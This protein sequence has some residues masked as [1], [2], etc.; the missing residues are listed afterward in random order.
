MSPELERIAIQRLNDKDPRSPPMPSRCCE[1]TARKL[2]SRLCGGNL[3]SGM[4]S[5]KIALVFSRSLIAASK[6]IPRSVSKGNRL[7]RSR[8]Q[9]LD[10]RPAEAETAAKP[11]LTKLAKADIDRMLELWI[12]PVAIQFA[13]GNASGF[14]PSSPTIPGLL[15]STMS[16]LRPSSRNYWARFPPGTTFSFPA[17][18]LDDAAADEKLFSELE[19]DLALQQL[20][21][22]KARRP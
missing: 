10:H 6:P 1:T 2:P 15:H 7:R 18:M 3:S 21:L 8:R 13:A 11:C 19:Q 12:E 22:V 5:G 4:T 16:R 14:T 9:E 17:A 20:K